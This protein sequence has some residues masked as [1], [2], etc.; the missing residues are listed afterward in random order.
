MKRVIQEYRE[1]GRSAISLD[2]LADNPVAVRL[3]Q[4]YG[5][6]LEE[7]GPG[8]AYRAEGPLCW[9]MALRFP[10]GSGNTQF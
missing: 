9:R 7:A 4:N 1:K 10:R 2:V 5:F 6:K 8:Y 3:Y